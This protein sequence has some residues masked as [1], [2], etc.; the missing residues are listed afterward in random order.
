MCSVQA[1]FG[2]RRNCDER[3][4]TFDME[5]P[6]YHALLVRGLATIEVTGG[7][8]DSYQAATGRVGDDPQYREFE[9]HVRSTHHTIAWI[10]IEPRGRATSTSRSEFRT[11]CSGLTRCEA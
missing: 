5:A 9:T 7:V 6:P 11:S 1:V 3:A 10:S 8:P 4:L 2:K